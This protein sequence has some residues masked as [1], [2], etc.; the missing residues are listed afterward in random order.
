[1]VDEFDSFVE[2]GDL[3]GHFVVFVGPFF[4]SGFSFGGSDF[5][6]FDGFVVILDGLF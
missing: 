6:G 3:D 2:G 4:V 1:V 5:D